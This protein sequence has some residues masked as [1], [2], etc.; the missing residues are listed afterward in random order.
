MFFSFLDSEAIC[1]GERLQCGLEK[2]HVGD[3]WKVFRGDEFK[4]GVDAVREPLR[5]VL[6]DRSIVVSPKNLSSKLESSAFSESQGIAA[7]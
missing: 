3:E 4:R 7:L 6:Q 5:M 2:Q 1:L